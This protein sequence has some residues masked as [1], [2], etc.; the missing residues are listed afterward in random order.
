MT[1]LPKTALWTAIAD[2]RRALAADLDG[3]EDWTAPSLC[4]G[5]TVREVL[6]HLTSGASLTFA[7][8]MAG[9]IK[10]RF[11][12][13]KQVD[14]QLRRRMG[15]SGA[16]TLARF[17]A[18]ATSTKHPIP[19]PAVLGEIV[20]HGE[21]I[22]RPLGIRRD[23]PVP[24][25][26]ALAVYYQRSNMTVPSGK[27]AAGLRLEATD[28]PFAAGD[29]PLVTGP[30]LALIMAMAGRAVYLDELS[31]EGAPEFRERCTTLK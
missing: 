12:F 9:V 2:E 3:F 13:D 17:G 21:D 16:E 27:R 1:D 7:G 4:E 10:C 11:D 14:M 6:A 24:V 28:G 19:V 26:T 15:D 8:W 20:V 30:T 5:L 18:A 25:L 31:G 29:G 23:H 22:R